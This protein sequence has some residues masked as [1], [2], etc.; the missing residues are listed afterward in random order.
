MSE[1]TDNNGKST[2]DLGPSPLLL[3]VQILKEM[4][5]TKSWGATQFCLFII[6]CLGRG[7]QAVQNKNTTGLGRVVQGG[8]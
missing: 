4:Q 8:V 2:I 6:N 7:R 5:K 3:T 1:V